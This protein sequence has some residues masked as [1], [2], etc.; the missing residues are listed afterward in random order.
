MIQGAVSNI[1]IRSSSLNDY[2]TKTNNRAVDLNTRR[3]ECLY[4]CHFDSLE[5]LTEMSTA[6]HRTIDSL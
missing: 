5:Y 6:I 3:E 1:W 2:R 4:A